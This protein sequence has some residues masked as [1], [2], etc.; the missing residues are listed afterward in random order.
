PGGLRRVRRL[1]DRGQP[2]PPDRRAGAELLGARDRAFP[3]L[4]HDPGDRR[5]GRRAHGGRRRDAG[6]GRGTAGARGGG[7]PAEGR[8]MTPFPRG[9]YRA[10][11]RYEPDRRPVEVDLSDNTNLC[12][13][14]PA[15][16]E[17]IRAA[18]TDD[19]ARYPELY[20]DVL[21]DAVAE[22]FGVDPECVTT[23]AGS[24]DVLDSAFRAAA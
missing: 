8:P 18:S 14:H 22:R 17:R 15:A 10:L 4:A 1:P 11:A 16:L 9:D 24:D 19:L 12:G 13:T 7:A 5:G 23:G 6:G 3:A 2:R 21:R 20:A